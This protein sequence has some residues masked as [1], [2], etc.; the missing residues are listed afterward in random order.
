MSGGHGHGPNEERDGRVVTALIGTVSEGRDLDARELQG[1]TDSHLD[2]LVDEV[3]SLFAVN[4]EERVRSAALAALGAIGGERSLEALLEILTDS[5]EPWPVG[6]EVL[7]VIGAW[8]ATDPAFR[9]LAAESLLGVIF[10]VPGL[11]TEM[12]DCILGIADPATF[13]L[14]PLL[15]RVAGLSDVERDGLVFSGYESNAIDWRSDLVELVARVA[16][17]TPGERHGASMVLAKAMVL[18]RE[19]APDR[20][21]HGYANDVAQAL[22][23]LDAQEFDDV[24]TQLMEYMSLSDLD[25]RGGCR[26]AQHAAISFLARAGVKRA[27]STIY[28][29]L[30]RWPHGEEAEEALVDI[31]GRVP[32]SCEVGDHGQADEDIPS[33]EI[34]LSLGV[35]VLFAARALAAREGLS[36]DGVITRLFRVG[37][38]A[39]TRD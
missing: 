24:V 23:D 17:R 35:D 9:N 5:G 28:E 4:R 16:N 8:S 13:A 22:L 12:M 15:E 36:M 25:E 37:Q 27:A 14:P 21:F 18:E 33:L 34:R 32:S 3:C 31:L 19:V 26:A 10:D 30:D 11:R 1:M 7:D 39:C 29:H 2:D 6:L 38:E 20:P